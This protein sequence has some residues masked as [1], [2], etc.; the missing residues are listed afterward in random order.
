LGQ[1]TWKVRKS[2][3]TEVECF[4]NWSELNLEPDSQGLLLNGRV[5]FH[6]DNIAK[7]DRLLDSLGIAFQYEFYDSGKQLLLKKTSPD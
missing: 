3:W 1:N 4:N 7:L 2:G 6:P 5:A